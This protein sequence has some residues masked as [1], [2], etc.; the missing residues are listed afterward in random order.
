MKETNA[1]WGYAKDDETYT[2]RVE[3]EEVTTFEA[4]ETPITAKIDIL[5]LKRGGGYRV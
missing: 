5:L 3:S 1:P 4:K 2:V